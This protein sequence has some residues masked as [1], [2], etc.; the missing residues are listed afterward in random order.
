MPSTCLKRSAATDRCGPKKPALAGLSVSRHYR[1]VES[2][3]GQALV[4]LN[5]RIAERGVFV[6]TEGEDRLVHLLGVEHLEAN[7]QMEV[8]YR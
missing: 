1:V 6:A 8:F 2:V 7:E 5:S 4:T 3:V